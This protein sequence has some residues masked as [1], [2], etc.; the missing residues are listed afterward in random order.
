MSDFK[1]TIDKAEDYFE[2]GIYITAMELYMDAYRID[3]KSFTETNKE[4]FAKAIFESDVV[5]APFFTDKLD[6]ELLFITKLLNQ[7]DTR[8]GSECIYTESLMTVI[9]FKKDTDAILKWYKKLDPNLLNPHIRKKNSYSDRD[10]YYSRVTK[11]LLDTKQY[12]KCI[13]LSY[14]ALSNIDEIMND[15]ENWFLIRIAKSNRALGNYQDAVDAFKQALKF[16]DNWSNKYA[17]AE[18]YYACENTDLALKTALDAALTEPKIRP[19]QKN[20]LYKLLKILFMEKGYK[21][22]A[23]EISVLIYSI[24]FYSN[25]KFTCDDDEEYL[26]FLEQLEDDGAVNPVAL[27][28]QL[29]KNWRNLFNQL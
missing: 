23:R 16:K 29:R 11:A 10:R 5:D 26:D 3:D 7:K 22:D 24:K 25:S 28:K 15:D 6:S 21:K 13:D 1:T 17:L 8:D 4:H 2:N 18:T 27:E 9:W 14:E 20:N 19:L 12:Q